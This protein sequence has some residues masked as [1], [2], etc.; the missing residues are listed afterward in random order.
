MIVTFFDR[1]DH[2]N[3]ENGNCINTTDAFFKILDATADRE[4]FFVELVG[5]RGFNLLVGVRRDGGCVQFSPSDGVPPYLMAVGNPALDGFSEYLIGGTPTPIPNRF[6]LGRDRLRAI[7][8][9][10]L[11]SGEKADSFVWEEI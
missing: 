1:Q 3:K 10:F 6:D 4:P 7:I 5:N 2:R 9:T 8:G 11:D